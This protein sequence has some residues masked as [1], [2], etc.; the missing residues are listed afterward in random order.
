MKPDDASL[1]QC[2]VTDWAR[3]LVLKSHSTGMAAGGGWVAW[4]LRSIIPR[5]RQAYVL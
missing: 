5:L 4:G 3:S 2:G 1:Q